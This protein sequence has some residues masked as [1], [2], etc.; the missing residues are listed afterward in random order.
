MWRS[1]REVG[2]SLPS[3][4]SPRNLSGWT[5]VSM[6]G[7][8]PISRTTASLARITRMLSG[9]ELRQKRHNDTPAPNLVLAL[10]VELL[11]RAVGGGRNLHLAGNRIAGSRCDR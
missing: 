8:I 1:I 5:D 9:L 7:G 4:A 10:L 6:P 11:V 3:R 2:D